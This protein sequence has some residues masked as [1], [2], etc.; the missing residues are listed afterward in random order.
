LVALFGAL[1]GV[2]LI[3][4]FYSNLAELKT[5]TCSGCKEKI[6][7]IEKI[8]SKI[9]ESKAP[10][11]KGKPQQAKV[12]D[13]VLAEFAGEASHNHSPSDLITNHSW[14]PD[15]GAMC[16]MTPHRQWLTPLQRPSGPCVARR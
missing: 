14:N 13:A 10:A 3:A 6:F 5:L 8:G 15:T 12:A 4:L 7:V 1:F 16:H 9:K 11:S 2:C